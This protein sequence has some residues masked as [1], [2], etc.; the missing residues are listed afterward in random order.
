[1]TRTGP[2]WQRR[3]MDEPERAWE[4]AAA[5]ARTAPGVVSMTGYRALA[6]PESVHLGLPSA[7]VTFIVGLDEGV[8]AAPDAASLPAAR[9]APLLLGGL[10]LHASHVHQRTGHAGIQLAL[11]PLAVRSLFGVPCAEL[12]VDDYDGLPLAGPAGRAL[13]ER[14]DPATPWEDA[15]ALV[16][17]HLRDRYRPHGPR[18]ELAGAWHLLAASGGRARIGDVADR[19]G[20]TPRHLG[21]LFHR[22][23]GRSPK[24]VAALMRFDHAR[25]RITRSLH[26][27]GR[28]DLAGAAAA[29]GYTDQAHLSRAF[30]RFTGLP[31]A[32][33]AARE[34]RNV[35]DDTPSRPPAWEP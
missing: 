2:L 32:A 5:P 4:F 27:T 10:H 24:T 34:F 18:P 33:W 8:R 26:R 6:V 20:L 14:L 16:A 1:M 25:R 3:S 17:A 22:E 30:T 13:Y 11:H 28:T 15:F 21:T 9:P 31:P 29:A 35:Q 7:S 12:G 23:V 19:V